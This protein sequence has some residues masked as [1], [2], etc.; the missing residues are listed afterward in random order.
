MRYIEHKCDAI[1]TFNNQQQFCKPVERAWCISG[2][3][4]INVS[5]T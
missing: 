4:H 5:N 2:H 3:A 1:L